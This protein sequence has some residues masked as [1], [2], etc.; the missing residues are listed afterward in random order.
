MS[1]LMIRSTPIIRAL[2]LD[3]SLITP[4]IGLIKIR[5]A[6]KTEL[7]MPICSCVRPLPYKNNVLYVL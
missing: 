6:V 4:H 3:L 5:M 7:I 2:F 1:A